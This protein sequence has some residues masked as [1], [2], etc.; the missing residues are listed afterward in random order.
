MKGVQ[1]MARVFAGLLLLGILSALLLGCSDVQ[2]VPDTTFTPVTST[3]DPP[4]APTAEDRTNAVLKPTNPTAGDAVFSGM[5]VGTSVVTA[6]DTTD[7]SAPQAIL[8]IPDPSSPGGTKSHGLVLK[9]T[10]LNG[11]VTLD[12]ISV[13]PQGNCALTLDPHT[14]CYFGNIIT[15]VTSPLT[16]YTSSF[17]GKYLTLTGLLI[18]F[19]VNPPKNGRVNW[20]LPTSYDLLLKQLDN[21][22][23]ILVGSMLAVYFDKIT[24]FPPTSNKVKATVNCYDK[25]GVL[26]AT[27]YQEGNVDQF[28][29]AYIR[30]HSS[31]TFVAMDVTIDLAN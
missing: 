27:V 16:R 12:Q 22:E 4:T 20:T 29:Y 9:Q 2:T 17:T 7:G 3:I 23:Y 11:N 21:G 8:T 24:S 5:V 25:N 26:K 14:R 18:T 10:A 30:P 6:M 13:V 31:V 15:P 28:G 19:T 1:I